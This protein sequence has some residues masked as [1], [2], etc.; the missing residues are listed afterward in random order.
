M[1]C[2]S[3]EEQRKDKLNTLRDEYFSLLPEMHRLERLLKIEVEYSLRDIVCE[4]DIHEKIIVTSRVKGCESAINALLKRQL[5]QEGQPGKIDPAQTYTL[6]T[7]KDLVG[8]RV[9]V[10]PRNPLMNKIDDALVKRFP[11]WKDDPVILSRG[12]EGEKRVLALKYYGYSDTH[13]DIN[14]EYQIAPLLTHLFW[15]VEH[16]AFYKPSIKLKGIENNPEME[17]RVEQVL[18]ALEEFEETFKKIESEALSSN[19]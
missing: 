18:N 19:S 10:F 6:K 12:E 7:L 17:T 15:Q 16:E 14:A 2:P 8:V 1:P 9:A 5:P 3:V 11:K 13:V 4:L